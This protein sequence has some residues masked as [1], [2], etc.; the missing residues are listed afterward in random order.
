MPT[1]NSTR[2]KG[3]LRDYVVEKGIFL[4][5]GVVGIVGART[6]WIQLRFL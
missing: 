5:L 4:V 2:G 1:L 6:G 3:H